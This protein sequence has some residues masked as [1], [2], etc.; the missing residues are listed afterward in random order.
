MKTQTPFFLTRE[1]HLDHM[2]KVVPFIVM[3]YAIQC[4]VLMQMSEL[5]GTTSVFIL[6]A[7][8]IAMISAFITYDVKH[9]VTFF[10]DRLESR[11]FFLQRTIYYLDIKSVQISGPKQTFANIRIRTNHTSVQFYFVDKADEIKLFLESFELIEEKKV[12]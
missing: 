11:F 3:G 8:L 12:A 5:L 7:S 10:E 9:Q 1:K 4:Y 2:V 6:G